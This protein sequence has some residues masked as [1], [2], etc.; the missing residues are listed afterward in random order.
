MAVKVKY[1][2]GR[3]KATFGDK[4]TDYVRAVLAR[5]EM[6]FALRYLH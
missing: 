6:R 5:D 1:E 2:Q 4:S 3:G